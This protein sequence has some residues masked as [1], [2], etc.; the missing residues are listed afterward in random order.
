VD[1]VFSFM[2]YIAENRRYLWMVKSSGG[3]VAANLKLLQGHMLLSRLVWFLSFFWPTFGD[4][5]SSL[6]EQKVNTSD[7]F[8]DN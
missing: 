3:S 2:Y 5:D 7:L 1:D 8:G 6:M 4:V